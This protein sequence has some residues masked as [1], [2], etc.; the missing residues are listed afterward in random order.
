MPIIANLIDKVNN[1]K[2]PTG[3]KDRTMEQPFEEIL[4]RIKT[5]PGRFQIPLVARLRVELALRRADLFES[6]K[7]QL[8]KLETAS[9][10]PPNWQML[11]RYLFQ[12][13]VL[14]SPSPIRLTPKSDDLDICSLSLRH[15][16]PQTDGHVPPP[17]NRG[18]SLDLEEA[19]AKATG[20]FLE[21]YPL[22]I[23]RNRMLLRGSSNQLKKRGYRFLDPMILAGFSEEQK[24]ETPD[25]FFTNDTPFRW[26]DGYSLFDRQPCLLPA[27]LVFWNY[28]LHGAEN[29]EPLLHERNTNGAAGMF[30]REE[31]I[32]AGLCELIQRDGL[33]I[34]W[35]NSL[36]PRRID[37]SN[38]KYGKI[39]QLREAC[40]GHNLAVEVLDFTSDINVPVCFAVIVDNSGNGPA[41]S[42]GG[43]CDISP[44]K[45]VERAIEEALGIRL[46]VKTLQEL[47]ETVHSDQSPQL[48]PEE[49]GNLG[50][51]Q[52]RV[53]FWANKNNFSLFQPTLA[54]PL[55]SF[56]SF[57]EGFPSFRSRREALF[58]LR[59][60][61]RS[62][63]AEYDIYVYEARHPVLEEVGYHSVRVIVPA[64]VPFYLN[65]PHKPLGA[66]RLKEVPVKLGNTSAYPH[67]NPLM[68]PFP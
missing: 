26:V 51:Q 49:M 10:I 56:E 40:L 47:K 2:I 55:K 25:F 27:Q 52:A 9:S 19:I 45:T 7:T 65:E 62:R 31:A 18:S 11:L 32:L 14:T 29:P 35:L 3:T 53:L 38:T 24:K 54:G 28:C 60:T 66:K 6:G 67:W 37:I 30:S 20:E 16:P 43:S 17:F 34:Y 50:G 12:R 58:K 57:K 22:L 61:F 33:L 21:R 68:Q 63:G 42:V 48:S 13:G 36:S 59:D 4:R 64:L 15:A 23:Y 5:P 8:K 39:P 44:E 46:W 41:V 1:L